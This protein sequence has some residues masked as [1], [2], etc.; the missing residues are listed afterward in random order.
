MEN[1]RSLNALM[2]FLD[3]LAEKGLMRKATVSSRKAAVGK[4]LGILGRE[5]VADVTSLDMDEVIK[6]F[7]NLEGRKYQPK[8]LATY[9]SRVIASIE[10]FK[11]YLD[12]P[13]GFKPLSARRT[14]KV[15]RRDSPSNLSNSEPTPPI[16]GESP[17]RPP[18]RMASHFPSDH[19]IPIPLRAD[20][21]VRVYGIPFD[22]TKKEADRIANVIKALAQ[23]DEEDS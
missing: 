6:R 10:D 17:R 11:N 4:V 13:I 18:G 9:K 7:S 8:T 19:I 12:D 2:D 16:S 15:K 22:L 21:V 23:V 20:L 14:R 3:Y 1:D 5:E